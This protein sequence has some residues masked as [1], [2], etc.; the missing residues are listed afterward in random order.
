[1]ARLKS[2][3]FAVVIAD[4]FAKPWLGPSEPKPNHADVLDERK[5]HNE[6]LRETT[7]M[8]T[9][10]AATKRHCTDVGKVSKHAVSIP[11]IGHSKTTAAEEFRWH[12]NGSMIFSPSKITSIKILVRDPRATR[13]IASKITKDTSQ[14]TCIGQ[15]GR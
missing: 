11:K 9:Q 14:A 8:E 10:P 5:R 15:H 13:S 7:D 6:L 12:Q 4:G 1:M 3:V 2:P